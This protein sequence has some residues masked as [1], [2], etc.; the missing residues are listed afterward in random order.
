VRVDQNFSDK[1]QMFGRV[2]Y[3]KRHAFFPGDFVGLASNAGFGA[4]NFDDLSFN[5]A[6][7]ETHTFSPT[8]INELRYGFSRLHT[9]SNPILANQAG[10]PAQF[11]IQGVSQ[12][13]GNY[14][15]PTISIGGLTGLGAGA[16]ASPNT[17][18]SDTSQLSENLTK[19][20]GKH[21]FK[22]WVRDASY[23]LSLD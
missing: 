17:R 13:D 22:G 2:S 7:S 6:V 1:D 11:G 19:I 5:S 3:S 4:G 9:I 14:G 20:Y 18:V 10:I 15:L 16:F 23:S 12:A 8:M 21:A